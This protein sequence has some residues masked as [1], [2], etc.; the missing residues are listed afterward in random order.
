[1]RLCAFVRV[2]CCTS[3]APVIPFEL[4][5]LSRTLAQ[6]ER[7]R[8]K[9]MRRLGDKFEHMDT[10][11][12]RMGERFEQLATSCAEIKDALRDLKPA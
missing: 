6:E 9:M 8:N 1:M 10:R 5:E 12:D 4:T 2:A 3:S 11:L 7:W